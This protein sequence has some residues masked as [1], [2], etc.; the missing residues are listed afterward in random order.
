[1]AD[2]TRNINYKLNFIPGTMGGIAAGVSGLNQFVDLSNEFFR[3]LGGINVLDASLV[4]LAA[5]LLSVQTQAASAFGEFE[6]GLTS[7]Q[8]ISQ[9]LTGN[10]NTIA[11]AS[12]QLSIQF[13]KDVN[14]IT[15]GLETLG[16][17]GLTGLDNQLNTLKDGFNLSTIEGMELNKALETLVQTTT[18]LGGNMNDLDFSSDVQKVNDLLVGTSMAGPLKVSDVAM[19]L[20]YTGGTAAVAGANLED[21]D[22]LEDLMGTIAVFAQ[23]GVV[24]DPA[25]TALRAFLTNPA[26]ANSNTVEGLEKIGLTPENLWED[27][28]EKMLPISD[29]VRI[30]NRAMEKNGLSQQE[31]IE[32]WSDIVGTKVGQQMLKLDADDIDETTANIQKQATAQQIA[33]QSMDNLNKKF[34]S[35]NQ[36]GQALWRS[37]GEASSKSIGVILDALTGLLDAL[38]NPVLA[39]VLTAITTMVTTNAIG[40]GINLFSRLGSRLKDAGSL[41]SPFYALEGDVTT[42]DAAE[43][44]KE[45]KEGK[46][47][48]QPST[49]T[50]N[51]AFKDNTTKNPISNSKDYIGSRDNEIVGLL[52]VFFDILND[53]NVNTG[54][55]AASLTG[56]NGKQVQGSKVTSGLLAKQLQENIQF[57]ISEAAENKLTNIDGTLKSINTGVQAIH[58]RL[59][60]Y[61]FGN[62]SDKDN[63]KTKT[64]KE[65]TQTKEPKK[66]AT[67]KQMDI[68][69]LKSLEDID[70]IAE[71]EKKINDKKDKVVEEEKKINN[72]KDKVAEAEEKINKQR[73]TITKSG[74]KIIGPENL[75]SPFN[76]WPGGSAGKNVPIYGLDRLYDTSVMPFGPQQ[77]YGAYA[78]ENQLGRLIPSQSDQF[79]TIFNKLYTHTQLADKNIATLANSIEQDAQFAGL[80]SITGIGHQRTLSLLGEF[81]SLQNVLN[82]SKTELAAVKNITTQNINSIMNETDK[83]INAYNAASNKLVNNYIRQTGSIRKTMTPKLSEIPEP[84][85]LPEKAIG[86]QAGGALVPLDQVN[87]MY[88][89]SFHERVPKGIADTFA[90]KILLD[91]NAN[92]SMLAPDDIELLNKLNRESTVNAL[93]F[94]TPANKQFN[95]AALGGNEAVFKNL[96]SEFGSVENILKRTDNELLAIN[97]VN[98][99][100]IAHIRANTS[101]LQKSYVNNMNKFTNTR[102]GMPAYVFNNSDMQGLIN[103]MHT[104]TMIADKN[105]EQRLKN[106]GVLIDRTSM[107][108]FPTPTTKETARSKISDIGRGMRTYG[109]VAGRA[110]WHGGMLGDMMQMG[111]MYAR[112]VGAT[113][114]SRGAK[115]T[116]ALGT[117]FSFF[118]PIEAGLIGVQAAMALYDS[119]LKEHQ[120]ALAEASNKLEESTSN[121]D[122]SISKLRE[123]YLTT[124]P[125]ATDEEVDEYITNKEAGMYD[126][127]TATVDEGGTEYVDVSHYDANTYELYRNTLAIKENT[128][129]YNEE[130][131]DEWFGIS[132]FFTEIGNYFKGKPEETDS[133]DYYEE[134]QNADYSSAG[135]YEGILDS[136]IQE[137]EGYTDEAK[138]IMQIGRTNSQLYPAAIDGQTTAAEWIKGGFEEVN[139]NMPYRVLPFEIMIKVM[140]QVVE[141]YQ[142][143]SAELSEQLSQTRSVMSET[144]G[145]GIGTAK[146]QTLASNVGVQETD[147]RASPFFVMRDSDINTYRT[148]L[149]SMTATQ[150]VRIGKAMNDY[151]DDINSLSA[152]M[153]LRDRQS[154]RVREKGEAID[155]KTGLRTSGTKKGTSVYDEKT[156]NEIKALANKTDLSYTEVLLATQLAQLQQMNSIAMNQLL[157]QIMSQVYLEQQGVDIAQTGNQINTSIAGSSAATSA[158]AA[159]IAALL[160][161]EVINQTAESF[162]QMNNEGLTPQQYYNKYGNDAFLQ[163]HYFDAMAKGTG[164][165]MESDAYTE[166]MSKGEGLTRV[167]YQDM[168]ATFRKGMQSSLATRVEDAYYS[169]LPQLAEMD[170]PQGGTG[171]G[172]GDGSGSGSGSDDDKESNKKNYVDLV[173]CN[174]KTIPKLN[175]NLFKKEPTFKIQNQNLKLRDIKINTQDKPKA[176]SSAVKNAIID[177]QERTNPKIIQDQEAE[178]NPVEATEGTSGTDVP[179]G[180]TQTN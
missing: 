56:K 61:R 169:Q 171:S 73:E 63:Q 121:Y 22:L 51:K 15:A 174:K 95:Y 39:T 87:K 130:V 110:F 34:E 7:V 70:K 14:E 43:D 144:F 161:A 102:E 117:I 92:R 152:R 23:R 128:Q 164:M 101:A 76:Y 17:A 107:A 139:W 68:G 13:G 159:S 5:T 58:A 21:T 94:V 170:T 83:A 55:I 27:G 75:K 160:G 49:S 2:I 137:L 98:Q 116:K 118:G 132:G 177:V 1:M 143:S 99:E 59:T 36:A 178:Y 96:A 153:V 180:T 119:A 124:Y 65:T 142:E 20:K 172:S 38:S 136:N 150:G 26:G 41:I 163:E 157:P 18:L 113:G 35:L 131:D 168:M 64:T 176:I 30:I 173:I 85:A 88:K 156:H 93:K 62:P 3:G 133:M 16:R 115:L 100:L 175:V 33:E 89:Q 84:K 108:N 141:D 114:T 135:L 167:G 67:K 90:K 122:D 32:V 40:R 44:A 77:K 129:K 71:D 138:Y 66:T 9:E 145:Y 60:G 103:D 149:G 105:E 79:K 48:K 148:T 57:G 112:N 123:S 28:G 54:K 104:Q 109:G 19:T 69:R 125:D 50:T 80:K 31:R 126:L 47:G 4:G 78:L 111:E 81:G 155:P 46:D 29:Q 97:G 53:I 72:K 91:N 134:L 179:T 154:N 52:D 166:L 42:E 147:A 74:T 10:M 25:G 120:E 82:S 37:F 24:G 8:A 11:S 162:T 165:N 6:K 45:R 140:K 146:R 127:T 86:Y 158:N 12:T 106:I 151:G